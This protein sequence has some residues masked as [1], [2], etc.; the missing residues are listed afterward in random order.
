M[1]FNVPYRLTRTEGLP[2]CQKMLGEMTREKEMA[3]R[4]IRR[5]ENGSSAGNE[6]ASEADPDGL[7]DGSE[8]LKA[9]ETMRERLR[10]LSAEEANRRWTMEGLAK[11]ADMLRHNTTLREK[12]SQIIGNLVKYLDAGQGGF[13]LYREENEQEKFLELI[14]CYAYGRNKFAENKIHIDG[15]QA[16][17]LIG[18]AFL[19]QGTIYLTDIPQNYTRI[20]SGLGDATPGYLLIVPI[21]NEQGRYGVLEIASF[22]PMPDYRIAFVEKLAESIASSVDV[23]LKNEQTQAMMAVQTQQQDQ[24]VRQED[25]LR[26]NLEELNALHEGSKQIQRELEHTFQAVDTCFLSLEL[27]PDGVVLKAN[28]AFGQLMGYAPDEVVG[29]HHRILADPDYAASEQYAQ[30]WQQLREGVFST[31]EYPRLTKAG[32][33]VWLRA[34]YYPI[35]DSHDRVIRIIKLGYDATEEKAQQEKLAAQQLMLAENDKLLRERTKSVQDKAYQRIKELKRQFQQEIE[36][37]NALIE[38]LT[39]ELDKAA[40]HS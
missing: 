27:S 25:E 13:F 7:T 22:Y 32:E 29:R 35:R 3:L 2:D 18:Q 20:T 17:G 16:E 12:A 34:T 1:K 36:E 40:N 37:K 4:L 23:L 6:G 15:Q 30:F 21:R 28:A 24:L 10:Q 5:M 19:E 38:Q 9:L 39:R 8:L 33:R 31:G 11:F 26:Q 14:A